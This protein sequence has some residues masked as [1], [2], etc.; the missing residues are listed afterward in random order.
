LNNFEHVVWHV[1][2]ILD[3]GGLVYQPT[4]DGRLL[5]RFSS[6]QVELRFLALGEQTVITIHSDV[7]ASVESR[8]PDAAVLTVVNDLNSTSMFG[9]WVF[10]PDTRRITIEHD[11]LGDHL[12]T[13][14]LMTGLAHVA[15]L[16]DQYD[17]VLQRHLGG[18]RAFE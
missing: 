12:Q 5:L 14:E 15:R 9:R 16:A 4:G 2:A 1:R 10:Y 11:L 6:A 7:L 13:D 17:D 3:E 18:T 8:V